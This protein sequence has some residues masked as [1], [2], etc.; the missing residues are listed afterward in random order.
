MIMNPLDRVF[1]RWCRVDR[2]QRLQCLT[3]SSTYRAIVVSSWL[4]LL[5][6]L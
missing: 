4:V 1:V 6:V 3:H 2:R 5:L